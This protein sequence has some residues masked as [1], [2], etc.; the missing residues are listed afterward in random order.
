MSHFQSP[1]KL[2]LLELP[3]NIFYSPLAGC[4][5]LPFRQMVNSYRPGLFF[6]EMVKMDALIRNDPSTYRMLDYQVDMHPIGAQIC[7]SKL[8]IA[9]ES[10]KIIE[11]LGFDV[12]DLNCGCP[13]DKVTKDGSGSGLLKTPQQ[14]GDIL[15]EMVQAVDIPVTV[16]IRSGWDEDQIVAPEVTKIAEEA[17]AVAITI[18][19]RTRK[20]AYRGNAIL[21]PIKQSKEVAKNIKVFGNGDIFDGP[22]AKGMFE[23]T[24]CDGIMVSRGTLGQPWIVSSLIQFLQEGIEEEYTAAH[25][26]DCFEQHFMKVMEYASEKQAVLDARRIGCWYIKKTMGAKEFRQKMSGVSS[27]K[28]VLE[29]IKTFKCGI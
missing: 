12:I 3:N 5:D 19:G 18:H 26:I 15:L 24:S 13:V 27:T 1:F 20:Q 8:E 21:D 25:S 17:G 9:K 29:L 14:I 6:C 16:K 28:E 23:E 2:G 11:D 22:S 10:A 7:G 4:S